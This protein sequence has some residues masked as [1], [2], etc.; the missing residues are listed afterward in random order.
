MV[1]SPNFWFQPLGKSLGAI[2]RDAAQLVA[3]QGEVREG[4]LQRTGFKTLFH[5]DPDTTGLDLALEAL[6]DIDQ[7]WLR[8]NVDTLIYLT[9]TGNRNAPGNGHLLH[10][11]LNLSPNTL[12][13]DINDACTGFIR[14]L[15]VSESLIASGRSKNI[16][17]VLSDT[18][19]KLYSDT[20][21][22]VSPLFSDGASAMLVSLNKQ[23]VPGSQFPPRNWQI[24][25]SS[26]SSE[27]SLADELT[28]STG[29]QEFPQG[30]LEMNGAGVFNFVVKHLR[31]TVTHT[32][33]EASLEL[34]QVTR[35]YVH[36]G[37]KAVVE[38]V[39]KTFDLDAEFQ[40]AA[41]NYGNVV[42]SAI[43]FQLMDQKK[44]TSEE[45]STLFLI[46]FGVGLTITALAIQQSSEVK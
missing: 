4:F 22:R 29:T 32:L 5:T 46:A 25:G 17:I 18:Y 13:L 16:L 38:A 14:S 7:E 28:V 20:N 11:L 40:F 19:S 36:Q 21:L 1:L 12:V 26:I 37:S 31:N 6:K 8:V 45:T 35:W 9:S 30:E 10:G 15:I 44:Q 34:S 43:P 42:G 23:K 39:S 3:S 2:P 27:G 41:E 33:S 24:L